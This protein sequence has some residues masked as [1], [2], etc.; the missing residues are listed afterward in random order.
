MRDAIQE[1]LLEKSR[2][3]GGRKRLSVTEIAEALG[4]WYESPEAAARIRDAVA[5]GYVSPVKKAGSV[6][7]GGE[8]MYAKYGLTDLC[9]NLGERDRSLL[10]SLH[11]SLASAR[12]WIEKNP[13]RLDTHSRYLL[14]CLNSYMWNHF[15]LP[16]MTLRERSL[17]VWGDEKCLENKRSMEFV[18][19]CFGMSKEGVVERLGC[20]EPLDCYYPTSVISLCDSR[21][22]ILVIE[23]KDTFDSAQR[24]LRNRPGHDLFGC[25]FDAVVCGWGNKVTAPGRLEEHLRMVFGENRV[26][27][28]S[29]WGDIDA[30]GIWIAERFIELSRY[31]SLLASTSLLVPAYESM[32]KRS[33]ESRF[34]PPAGADL[35]K[36][37]SHTPLSLLAS[38]KGRIWAEYADDVVARGERIPQEICNAAFLERGG[39]A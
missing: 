8:T 28:V 18:C 32:A 20:Y 26:F 33:M 13:S 24:A 27:D 9:Y 4:C 16:P 12:D 14:E 39:M 7:Y 22:S 37:P 15:E 6:R 38:A 36:V 29:Y 34:E 21:M 23:N 31:C 10:S 30:E 19:R 11:C 17:E 35:G 1:G 3:L 2:Q 25:K 5:S